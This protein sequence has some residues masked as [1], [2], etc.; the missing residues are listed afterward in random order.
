[1]ALSEAP[2]DADEAVDGLQA[3][4][5]LLL[6]VEHARQQ[7]RLL[8]PPGPAALLLRCAR[9]PEDV[10]REWASSNPIALA[11]GHSC[12]PLSFAGSIRSPGMLRWA[13]TAEALAI[14]HG[15]KAGGDSF[16]GDGVGTCA[17]GK[18]PHDA[19]WR[20]GFHGPSSA[21]HLRAGSRAFPGGLTAKWW[22]VAMGMVYLRADAVHVP[23]VRVL[24]HLQ[25]LC[26]EH[27]WID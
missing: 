3:A 10:E 6:E 8:R 4:G 23:T 26:N 17:H 13:A 7:A 12:T 19:A 22:Q 5:G 21:G 9:R 16:S 11:S 18:W 20:A 25:H 1:M 14:L 15:S 27:P 24:A 2:E